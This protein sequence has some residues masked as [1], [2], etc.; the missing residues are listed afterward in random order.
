MTIEERFATK[1]LASF[2]HFYDTIKC[3]ITATHLQRIAAAAPSDVGL[4]ET[5]V[6]MTFSLHSVIT[7]FERA[8]SLTTVGTCT[9]TAV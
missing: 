9:C 1:M 8:D 4:K 3:A 7:E 6:K 5:K 2:E